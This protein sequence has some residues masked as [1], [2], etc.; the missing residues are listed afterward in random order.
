M[1]NFKSIGINELLNIINKLFLVITF[2]SYPCCKLW[3]NIGIF[4]QIFS[5]QFKRECIVACVKFSSLH[6]SAVVRIFSGV[7]LLQF[8]QIIFE[9]WFKFRPLLN[10]MFRGKCCTHF[11]DTLKFIFGWYWIDFNNR[12]NDL[13]GWWNDLI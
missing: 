7:T 3:L 6:S 13:R 10:A 12:W 1:L 8:F 5:C 2:G 9:L 4:T 11:D